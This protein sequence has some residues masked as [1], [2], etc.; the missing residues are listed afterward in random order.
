MSTIK[1]ESADHFV[2]S[3]PSDM[4]FF[5]LHG[6]DEGLIHERAKAIVKA[7]LAGEMDPLRLSRLDADG[8]AREP[9]RIADEVYAVS[10]FGGFRVLWI[11]AGARDLAPMLTPIFERPPVDCALVVEAGSLKKGVSLRTL[12]EQSGLAASVECYSDD[13]K[14]LVTVVDAEARAAGLEISTEAREYLLTLLGSDRLT[15][16]GEVAKLMMYAR[17]TGRVEIEDVEAIVADAA[18]SGVDGIVDDALLGNMAEVEKGVGRYFGDGGD[19]GLLLTRFL[20]RVNLLRQIRMEM[21]AGK[22]FDAALQT[23]YVRLP[24]APRQALA[25]QAER[26]SLAN[27]SKRLPALHAVAARARRQGGLAA[28]VVTRALWAFASGARAGR[29]SV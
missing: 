23:L 13:R 7:C 15:S 9:G 4:R 6:N 2:K 8:L 19:A 28:V 18:P 21:D 10:M 25:R 24:T 29:G 3:P 11:D 22:P 27:L 1:N 12:F 5:L 17:G 26:W 16:R 20:A 14:A